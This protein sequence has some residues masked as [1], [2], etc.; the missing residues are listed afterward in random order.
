MED[1]I[2]LLDQ[3]AEEHKTTFQRFQTLEQVANDVEA[4]AGL[5]KSK[6]AFIPGRLNQKAGL[7]QMRELLETIVSGLEEHF[8]HEETRLLAAFE[9]H[10][11]RRLASALHS[12]LQGHKDLR[13]RLA[14]SQRQVAEL[15][16]GEM[17]RNVWVASA[18]DMRAY[19]SHTLKLLED[20]ARDEQRLLQTLKEQ[21]QKG[22]KN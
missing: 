7:Q 5:E 8:N 19:L 6:E 12:L 10:G 9:Q 17:T 14:S 18:N 4:I 21:L 20:H 2:A 13:Q 11:D 3:I 22:N 16:K 1:V 15:S